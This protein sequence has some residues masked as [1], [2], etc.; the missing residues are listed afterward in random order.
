MASV[1][2]YL[3]YFSSNLN[4]S[5]SKRKSI[6]KSKDYLKKIIT[7]YSKSKPELSK[8][9]FF[10]QGSYKSKTLIRTK[11]DMCDLDLGIYFEEKPEIESSTLQNW[12]YGCTKDIT[13]SESNRKNKC[14]RVNY[15]SG[16][17][18]DLP[19]YYKKN[20]SIYIIV[21]NEADQQ[22]DTKGFAKWYQ[23]IK[24]D[25][26][27]RQVR[28]LKAFFDNLNEKYISGIAITV[29]VAK[30]FEDEEG[31][32]LSFYK[33]LKNIINS[34]DKNPKCEFPVQPYDDLFEK[35]SDRRINEILKQF[36]KL[37]KKLDSIIKDSDLDLA[38]ETCKS[39]FGKW[40]EV[41]KNKIINESKELKMAFLLDEGQVF[42]SNNGELNTKIGIKNTK[43]RFYGK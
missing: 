33:T 43:H 4:I 14:I 12:I 1:D 9:S 17:H 11:D 10:I 22:S 19:I 27:N 25:K 13:G 18:I 34:I 39:V 5:K 37:Y 30:N 28:Y 8:I 42:T 29:L 23:K 31:E 41:D 26:M 35:F 3:K 36:E 21:K 20:S 15:S 32:I 40:F 2:I 38:L 7:E 16:Y 6:K 24:D